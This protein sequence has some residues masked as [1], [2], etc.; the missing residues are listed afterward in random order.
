MPIS[1]LLG[2][3]YLFAV[4]LMSSCPVFQLSTPSPEGPGHSFVSQSTQHSLSIQASWNPWQMELYLIGS[5]AGSKYGCGRS[6]QLL[7]Q[8]LPGKEVERTLDHS[9]W[10]LQLGRVQSLSRGVSFPQQRAGNRSKRGLL[11]NRHSKV[12]IHNQVFVRIAEGWGKGVIVKWD[13][14][15][16]WK[17]LEVCVTLSL[18]CLLQKWSGKRKENF[19]GTQTQWLRVTVAKTDDLSLRSRTHMVAG[20]TQLPPVTLWPPNV[21]H[22]TTHTHYIG[23]GFFLSTMTSN[24]LICPW[25]W[26][27]PTLCFLFRNLRE[28][29][30][31]F[32]RVFPLWHSR[33]R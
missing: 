28:L 4:K 25:Y 21:W 15:N 10:I 19:K 22:G 12:S 18:L 23:N 20:E 31:V 3:L 5:K 14:G 32:P 11:G 26:R 29:N 1:A 27:S 9:K 13:T 30:S 33:A 7:T 24:F 16:G 6:E 2:S 17:M 8:P